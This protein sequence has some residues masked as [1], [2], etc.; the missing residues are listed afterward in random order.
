[1]NMIYSVNGS[2]RKVIGGVLEGDVHR[3]LLRGLLIS[4]LLV[5]RLLRIPGP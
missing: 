2:E 1:M 5:G 4:R 3:L